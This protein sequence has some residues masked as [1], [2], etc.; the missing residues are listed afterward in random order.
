M[1]IV[2]TMPLL[3]RPEHRDNDIRMLYEC[4]R[5]LRASHDHHIILYNQGSLS[6]NEL[7]ALI[8]RSGISAALIG[9][10]ENIGIA[11]A[12][13]A[14][15]RYIEQHCPAVPYI[16]EIHVDMLFPPDWYAPL[17]HCLETTD[18][19][20]ICP[21]I[22]T[23]SGELQPLGRYIDLPGNPAAIIERLQQLPG[24]NDGLKP[25]FVHPVVHRASLLRELGG[26]DTRF[27]TG[28]QGFEDD[29]LLLGYS[30]YMGLRTN[31]RPKCTLNS[32]VYH[33]TLGQRMSLSGIQQEFVR[34]EEG[35]VRQYGFYGL[36]HLAAIHGEKSY[37]H[38]LYHK[39]IPRTL[40][41]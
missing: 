41:G 8:F 18:E 15:F 31:W 39:Y 29:S 16:S 19:P 7:D 3:I 4:L 38:S 26:Y 17:I 33:A 12:R 35:L 2:H 23:A 30:Y 37:F 27:L 34:N 21:G 22:L 28:K 24:E 13:M 10:G 14:C 9:D 32:W 20:V 11:A 36:K 1:N 6:A 40:E 25:G 5:S